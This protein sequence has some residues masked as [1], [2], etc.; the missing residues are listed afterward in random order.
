MR[1]AWGNALEEIYQYAKENGEEGTEK[2]GW[3]RDWAKP[4]HWIIAALIAKGE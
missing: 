1:H 2:A 3:G 4:I